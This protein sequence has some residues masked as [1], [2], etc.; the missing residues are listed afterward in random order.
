[1]F[2]YL[3]VFYVIIFF[4]YAC[5]VMFLKTRNIR[6]IYTFNYACVLGTLI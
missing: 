6:P 4:E 1:M 3:H 5:A 2:T